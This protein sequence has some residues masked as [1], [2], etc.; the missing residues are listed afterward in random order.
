MACQIVRDKFGDVTQVRAANGKESLAYKSLLRVVNETKDLSTIKNQF[1]S[2]EGKHINSVDDNKELALALYKQLYSPAFKEWFGD[3]KAG[4]GSKV[5]DENGEPLLVYHHSR[6]NFSAFDE[7]KT[8]MGS[9]FFDRGNVRG[10]SEYSNGFKKDGSWGK[11]N[12]YPVFLNIRNPFIG[13]YDEDI[14]KMDP[15]KEDIMWSGGHFISPEIKQNLKSKGIDGLIP[16][17]SHVSYYVAFDSNQIKSGF[18]QGGFD[19]SSDIYR[20]VKGSTQPSP[21]SPATIKKVKEFLN[22][23]GVKVEEVENIKVN[24]QKI[25][26]TGLA[27]PM[28]RLIQISQGN[29][30][31][32]L[33]E[34]A[35]HIAVELV[36]QKNPKLFRDMMA[37]IGKY[38]L[39]NDVIRDYKDISEY[40]TS[41]GKPDIFKIKKETIGKIL[42]QTIIDQNEGSKENPAFQVQAKTWWEKIVD[43]LKELFGKAGMNPFQETAEAIL[44]GKETLGKAADLTKY[45]GVFLQKEQDIIDKLKLN[46]ANIAKTDEGFEINGNKIKKSVMDNVAD[47]LKS[48]FRGRE[49]QVANKEFNEAQHETEDKF[50][51]DLKDILDRYIDDTG[52]RRLE[53]DPHITPSAMDPFDNTIYNTLDQHIK[54]RLESYPGG[55][56]F[57]HDINIYDGINTAGRVDFLAILPDGYIDILQFKMPD[58]LH[59]QTDIPLYKQESYN[60]EIE[61]LRKILQTGYKVERGQFRYT[62]AIPVRATYEG[63]QWEPGNPE[64]MV[65]YK[66]KSVKIGNIDARL[67]ED[68]SL[69][70]IASISETTGDKK[71]DKFITRLRGLVQKMSEERV[72]PDKRAEKSQRIAALLASIRKLQVQ[73]KADGVLA[74]AKLIVKAQQEKYIRL[75][76]AF[77]NTDPSISTLKEINKIA[78]DILDEKDQVEIYSDLYRVFKDVFDDGSEKAKEVLQKAREISDDAQDSV[79]KYWNLSVKFRTKKLAAMF[80]IQDE[81][82]PE[83]QLTWYRRMVRS[84]SQSSLKAGAILWELVKKINNTYQLEFRDRLEALKKLEEP[85]KEWLKGRSMDSLYSKI[86][87]MKDGKWNGKFIQQYHRDFYS[88][89]REHQEKGGRKWVLD[90]IDVDAYRDWYRDMHETVLENYRDARLHEDDQENDKRIK[91]Q[92]AQ[93]EDT[94]DIDKPGGAGVHNY[95]LKDFPLDNKWESDEYKE[96]QKGENK[97]L[98]DLY[99]YWRSKLDESLELGMIEEHNGWSWFPNVRKNRIEKLMSGGGLGLL[100][101]TK[102]DPEDL[103]FGKIDPLTGKPVD[104]VHANYVSDLG[105]WVK[106][107]DG[108][109]YMDYTDKSKDL[110][111]VMALWEREIVK[112]K[113]KTESEGLARM[114][115]YTELGQGRDL[116]KGALQTSKT[117][118]LQKDESGNPIVVDND[119]NARYIKDHIDAVYYGKGTANESDIAIDIPYKAAVQRINKIFGREILTVPDKET[120]NMSGTKGLEAINRF[121]MTKTLGVNVFTSAANLFGGTINT[122]INQGKF[123]DKKDVVESETDMVSGKFW[124][125]EESK[126]MAGLLSYFHPFLEDKTNEDIRKMSLSNAVKYFSSDHLFFMQRWSDEHVNQVIGMSFIKNAMV[127]DGKIVNIREYARKELGHKDKYLGTRQET[128]EFDEKLEKRIEELKKSPEALLNYATIKDD[129]IEIPGVDRLGS[130]TINFREQILS[131]IKDALGNTSRE[132]LSLYKRSI[133]MQSFFMFKN[134]IPRMLDVR[135]QSL[136]YNPGSQQYEWGRVRMLGTAVQYYLGGKVKDLKESLG[137][138]QKGIVA[139][140]KDMY[141]RKQ[142]EFAEQGEDFDMNEAEFIDMYIKGVRSEFKEIVLGLGLMGILFAARAAQP[143]KNDDPQSKGMY[144]WALRGIDKLQDEV[145]FFY[146]PSS[147]TDIVNGSTFPAVGVFVDIEKFIKTGIA[148]AYY[149]LIGDDQQAGKEHPAKYVFKI[150]PV[151]KELVT[152]MAIFNN[153][154]AKDFGIKISSQNGSTR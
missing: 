115:Y 39:F 147:F 129:H 30:D 59:K 107:A 15:D 152:Y 71:L 73:E 113:L 130:Q 137:T 87:Q 1:K 7:E 102:I 6:E 74:S 121:Y 133:I 122:Y 79:D 43:W 145:N 17:Y 83:K 69:V 26:A 148:K 138:D 131:F 65:T 5:I 37:Q 11:L 80:G 14:L 93:F 100:D 86:L 124:A 52:V 50:H 125:T 64:S 84:L 40:R 90:N 76:D 154:F 42:A 123:F 134:W 61:G 60:V 51:Q 68:E 88:T 132:D 153:D 35:M 103:E 139:I 44:E 144:K 85:V 81:F 29:Y 33:T 92:I 27:D 82:N 78:S 141:R 32:A 38:G 128:K 13:Y 28:R 23:V 143:P 151:T 117:G 31:V 16:S 112:F 3:W 58:I 18:N 57:F 140:A 53:E 108:T 62:R 66:P 105:K 55:T 101:R 96:L 36:E 111:S 48:R 9:F 97:P 95:R 47:Y 104:E 34:E 2:W 99:N 4:M 22:R 10:I 21:A 109:G 72:S 136:K 67:I 110:F 91:Q 89:L 118:K 19:K 63:V 24:G 146:N 54:E 98:L 126:K 70:P 49:L 20:Q 116:E 135:G 114:L 8:S 12:L 94:F 106:Q 77:D 56:K 45:S 150:L 149:K 120:I 41:D 119:I 127:K 75:N 25:G 46:N 142:A